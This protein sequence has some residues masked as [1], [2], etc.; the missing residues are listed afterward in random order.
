MVYFNFN[1]S[2]LADDA[3][4]LAGD[5]SEPVDNNMMSAEA[6]SEWCFGTSEIRSLGACRLCLGNCWRCLGACTTMI[7][8]RQ[9]VPRSGTDRKSSA[10]MLRCCSVDVALPG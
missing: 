10:L 9:N 4:E 1:A 5:A 2:D 6:P 3:S 8:C 7:R